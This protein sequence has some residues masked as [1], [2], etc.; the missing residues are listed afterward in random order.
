[1]ALHGAANEVELG[2][3]AELAL[4]IDE[5][6]AVALERVDAL[7]EQV[8][9]LAPDGEAR[10]DFGGSERNAGVGQL[11]QDRLARRL[12]LVIAIL[13]ACR[14]AVV[15]GTACGTATKRNRF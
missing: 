6:L 14:P 1:M 3:D 5:D 9:L 12:R 7:I 13:P 11:T 2:D 15:R 8:L 4:A 10:G